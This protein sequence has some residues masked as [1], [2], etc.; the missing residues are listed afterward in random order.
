MTVTDRFALPLLAAAQAQKEVTHNEALAR[1]DALLHAVVV[2]VGGALPASPTPGQSWIVGTG[3]GGAWAG[4]D[5]A[6]ATWTAGGWRFIAPVTGMAVW[7]LADQGL[8]R[9]TP[10]GWSIGSRRAALVDP[11]GG[12]VRDE[13]ARTAIAAILATLRTHGLIAI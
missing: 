7:S 6:L 9:R 11:S 12:S 13:E 3:A 8:A 2:A 5:G 1:V 4:Q 10:T